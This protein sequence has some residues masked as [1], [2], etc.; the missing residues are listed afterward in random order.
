MG[1]FLHISMAT[2]TTFPSGSLIRTCSKI[3]GGSFDQNSKTL[4]MAKNRFFAIFSSI[5]KKSTPNFKQSFSPLILI[6]YHNILS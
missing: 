3:W 1:L 6:Y 2:M 5:F 4:K